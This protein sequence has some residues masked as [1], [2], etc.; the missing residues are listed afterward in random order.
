VAKNGIYYWGR[1]EGGRTPLRFLDWSSRRSQ[2]LLRVSAPMGLTASPDGKT[3]FYAS[4]LA[5]PQQNLWLL[6]EFR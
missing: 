6:E 2:E 5:P 1:P 4:Y 3:V